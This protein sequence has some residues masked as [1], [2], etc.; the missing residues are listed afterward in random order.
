MA[1]SKKYD[2]VKINKALC[3]YADRVVIPRE[4][5]T[6]RSQ[7][8]IINRLVN[9]ILEE[10]GNLD[11]RFRSEKVKTNGCYVGLKNTGGWNFDVLVSL[12]NL[13]SCKILSDVPVEETAVFIDSNDCDN[14]YLTGV[15][16]FGYVATDPHLTFVHG[17]LSKDDVPVDSTEYFPCERYLSPQRVLKHFCH[18]AEQAV[19]KLEEDCFLERTPTVYGVDVEIT[20]PTVQLTI[21]MAGQTYYVQLVPSVKFPGFPKSAM[22]WGGRSERNDWLSKERVDQIKSHFYAFPNKAP[23]DSDPS[24]LWCCFYLAKEVELVKTANRG[25]SDCCRALVEQI[26][27]TL[28]EENSQDFCPIDSRIVRIAFLQQCIQFPNSYT[29]TFDKIGY[30]FIDIF[31]AIL[32]CLAFGTCQHFFIQETNLLGGYSVKELRQVAAHLQAILNDIV[33]RPMKTQFLV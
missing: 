32:D 18:L 31:E 15:P 26:M 8:F 27:R 23:E 33:T 4:K 3:R 9:P 30:A 29:W 14:P 12:N 25:Q 7:N 13:L 1:S 10:I 22:S 19:E 17:L 24:R 2:I 5:R 16:G 28:C 20:G 6:K 21:L 11:D